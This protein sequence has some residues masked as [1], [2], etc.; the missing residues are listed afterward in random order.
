MKSI[1]VRKSGRNSIFEKVILNFNTTVEFLYLFIYNL[2][3]TEQF[4]E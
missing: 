4:E 1:I 2:E 3:E